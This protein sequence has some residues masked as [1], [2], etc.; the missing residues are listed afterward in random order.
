MYS[1][2]AIAEQ[3]SYWPHFLIYFLEVEVGAI[4]SGLGQILEYL[5]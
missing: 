4:N 1:G 3:Q 5:L 2:G